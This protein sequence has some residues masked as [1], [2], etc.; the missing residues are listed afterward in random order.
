MCLMPAAYPRA[1]ARRLN[2]M[3]G[4]ATLD[5]AG[6]A[7]RVEIAPEQL[8]GAYL[9]VLA[10]LVSRS[11]SLELEGDGGPGRRLLAGLAGIGAGGKSTFAAV[12][13]HLA[14]QLLLAAQ[15]AI[16]GVDGWHYP[17]AVLDERWTTDPAGRPIR[18][19]RRKGGPDSY[20]VA[21]LAAAMREL[22]VGG[23]EVKLPGYDRRLHEPVAEAVTVPAEPRIVLMEGNYLLSDESPWDEVS[24]LLDVSFY[25]E[26][27]L[28]AARERMIGRHI[29]GGLTEAEA[30]RKYEE[31]DGLNARIIAATAGKAD[32]VVR[33]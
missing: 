8:K 31:N 1:W 13:E 29:R 27:D 25:L 33:M 18:L 3:S 7:V 24:G 19:R 4:T 21:A 23:R 17:N 6:L 16:V 10:M 14:K 32:W 28:K 12:L 5:V 20:D 30:V 11:E 15:F 2:E 22:R 26:C 9:P